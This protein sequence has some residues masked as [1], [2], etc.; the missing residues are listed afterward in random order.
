MP[1]GSLCAERNVIGSALSDDL[2]L[3]RANLRMVAV[4]S[5]SM[6]DPDTQPQTP[7]PGLLCLPTPTNAATTA[8]TTAAAG[9]LPPRS[10]GAAFTFNETDG[11]VDVEASLGECN[12]PPL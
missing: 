5:V 11:S 3:K 12:T 7:R 6:A 4:L 8:V 2:S 10:I 1:T 9:S